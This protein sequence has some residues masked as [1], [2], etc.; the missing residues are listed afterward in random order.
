MVD[1]IG[2]QIAQSL[3]ARSYLS[4]ALEESCDLS[5][6]AQLCNYMRCVSK[7]FDVTEEL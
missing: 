7:Q 1:E 3:T 2:E 6:T 4:L 5:D